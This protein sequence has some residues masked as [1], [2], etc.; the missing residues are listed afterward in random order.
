MRAFVM[1][2]AWLGVMFA[3]LIFLKWFIP[4]FGDAGFL[5]WVAACCVIGWRLTA[6]QRAA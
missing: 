1:I 5:I 6:G 4:A 3:M 2:A